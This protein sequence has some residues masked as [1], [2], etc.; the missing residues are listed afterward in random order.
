MKPK[1][2]KKSDLREIV[3]R[4]S[5]H[6]EDWQKVVPELC[7]WEV[8]NIAADLEYLIEGE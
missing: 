6:L 1:R 3:R 8:S 5:K 4:L 7:S 2:V